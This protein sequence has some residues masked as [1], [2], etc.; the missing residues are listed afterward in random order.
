M[1]INIHIHIH[2]TVHDHCPRIRGAGALSSHLRQP[3]GYLYNVQELGYEG[4]GRGDC[5]RTFAST[6]NLHLS[7]WFRCSVQPGTGALSHP[8]TASTRSSIVGLSTST[9]SKAGQHRAGN[10]PR[11]RGLNCGLVVVMV[12]SGVRPE[13]MPREHCHRQEG[14]AS[15]ARSKL[16]GTLWSTQQRQPRIPGHKHKGSSSRNFAG[17]IRC[18]SGTTGPM[19]A[20][21]CPPAP[22]TNGC[23][24]PDIADRIPLA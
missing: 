24:W 8:T 1:V 5:C 18:C 14:A 6:G 16:A 12:S 7:S 15:D 3:P 22:G 21:L 10:S 11:A 13:E 9:S 2:N 23:S 4:K 17:P 20:G 19:Q